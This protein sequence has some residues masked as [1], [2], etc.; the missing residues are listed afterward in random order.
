VRFYGKT[1]HVTH[2][3]QLPF[4]THRCVVRRPCCQVDEPLPPWWPIIIIIIIV[5]KIEVAL[6]DW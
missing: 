3:H 6:E 4:R 5:A 2:V 1:A